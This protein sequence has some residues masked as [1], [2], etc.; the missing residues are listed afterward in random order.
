MTRVT[1]ILLTILALPF[2]IAGLAV[3][4]AAL[5]SLV[6]TLR[7]GA[8]YPPAGPFVEVTGGRL[9][10]IQAGPANGPPIVLLHGASANASDPME[11]IGRRLASRGF[12]II[13][14]DRPGFGWSDRISGSAAAAPVVQA[15]IIAE[16]L[17]RMGVGPAIVFGHSWAG[18]LALALALDHPER[19][20]GL[21]LAA[22]VAMPMPDRLPDLPWYWQLAV[23]PPVAWL[24]S[25]TV[26]PPLARH[27]L[28]EAARR[29]FLPQAAMPAYPETAR[30]ALV[31][32]PET[33]L[34]NVQDLLGLS[35]A[36]AVQS[37]RYREI[38]IP[39]LVIS[40]EADPIVRS[41]TQA[42]PL[43]GAIPGAR[44]VLLPGIGHMLQFVA[45]ER[46]AHEV[47]RLSEALK[48]NA[49]PA[50]AR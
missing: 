46:L 43:A 31:L 37:P 38:R 17:E 39:T 25:R 49:V 35:T 7:V 5:V 26:G 6:I 50:A 21:V 28:P 14:F 24:L 18:A 47:A 30:A 42:V 48:A 3:A 23:K 44:L 11:G 16:A 4:V 1:A 19:V 9:A 8:E 10:T 34:A 15:R 41:D 40:G 22:P 27:F 32:R 33:L 29:V 12:R 36:L 20:S 2:A 45:S 13:A